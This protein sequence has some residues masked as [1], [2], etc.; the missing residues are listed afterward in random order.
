VREDPAS[1]W[2]EDLAA[3]AAAVRGICRDCLEAESK[4]ARARRKVVG[5]E[6]E[7]RRRRGFGPAPEGV[8]VFQGMR[9]D[10]EMPKTKQPTRATRGAG[11]YA[12]EPWF[13]LARRI[14]RSSVWEEDPATRI[15][16]ITLL[17]LAQLP[18]NRK[19]GRGVVHITR[20]NLCREAFV[21][22]EQ[23]EHALERLTAPDPTS[24]TAPGSGRVEVLP[25]GYRILSFELYH[26][27]AEYE[28][29]RAQRVAAGRARASKAARAAGRFQ[30]AENQRN[31]SD[32]LAS[33]SEPLASD[34]Q[35]KTETETE[36][37][38]TDNAPPNPPASAGAPG[39]GGGKV[40]TPGALTEAVNRIVATASPIGY[41]FDREA[42]RAIRERLLGGEPE[43]RI[44]GKY[45]QQRAELEALDYAEQGALESAAAV[46][47]LEAAELG[48]ALR[49]A[50]DDEGGAA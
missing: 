45:E 16:W 26:D 33:S 27:A 1:P 36:T 48:Q 7:A 14:F 2:R 49:L 41:R 10:H 32:S 35:Y 19:H 38:K 39:G 9:G 29:R 40:W 3:R 6:L 17:H 37:E 47:D 5:A 31:A 11:E 43:D 12:E 42:R 50:G 46:D 25:N 30:G 21:S 24:R 4:A 34:Q 13:K 20:G 28:T 23:L 44:R 8:D 15:V 22:A 18:E